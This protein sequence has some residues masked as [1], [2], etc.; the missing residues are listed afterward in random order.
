MEM[1]KDLNN[2]EALENILEHDFSTDENFNIEENYKH[3]LEF[4]EMQEK[5][6]LSKEDEIIDYLGSKYVEPEFYEKI[7]KLRKNIKDY[8]KKYDV[9]SD[10]VKSILE[11]NPEDDELNRLFGIVKFML[12]TF[13]RTVEELNFVFRFT[14]Q[15]YNLVNK[16]LTNESDVSGQEVLLQGMDLLLEEMEQWKKIYKETQEEELHLPLSMN[17][18]YL[19]YHFLSKKTVKGF[20][21]KFYTLRSVMGKLKEASDVFEAYKT[22]SERLKTDFSIWCGA[23][24]PFNEEKEEVKEKVKEEVKDIGE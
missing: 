10:F 7:N 21:N 15:E 14:K 20:S 16:L 17:S 9:N 13:N 23:I 6:K 5:A 4:E 18:T 1:K 22:V 2:Q 8:L 11:N 24:T 3:V 12:N 19:M